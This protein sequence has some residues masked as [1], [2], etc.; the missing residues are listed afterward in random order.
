[1]IFNCWLVNWWLQLIMM[2]AAQK[3]LHEQLR[4][5]HAQLQ[6]QI[7]SQQEELARVSEQLL[8]AQYGA[9]GPTVLKVTL[10]KPIPNR[11]SRFKPT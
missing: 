4:L 1:M 2:T 6:R 5:K 7:L 9:W 11:F 10:S 3:Q 8:L